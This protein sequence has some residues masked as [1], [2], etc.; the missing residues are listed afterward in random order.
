MALDD[1]ERAQ[2]Q[3]ALADHGGIDLEAL[4]VDRL[5]GARDAGLLV[6]HD[7]EDREVPIRHAD[8][9]AAA[10]PNARL[11]ATDGLGHRRILR[12]AAVIAE[13]VAFASHGV[14]PPVSDLVREVD[15]CL[16]KM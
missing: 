14:R 4:R 9:L 11:V 7:R 1:D 6:V 12:D 15:R 3:S 5:A 13:T 10:W 16:E 8:R 2:L